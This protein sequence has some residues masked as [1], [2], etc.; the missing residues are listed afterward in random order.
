[1]RSR[2]S[3]GTCGSTLVSLSRNDGIVVGS[4]L[5]MALIGGGIGIDGVAIPGK[6]MIGTGGKTFGRPAISK[7]TSGVGS[8][9]FKSGRSLRT[10]RIL[11]ISNGSRL[12]RRN[13]HHHH[14]HQPQHQV[15]L[16]VKCPFASVT[17]VGPTCD[18]DNHHQKKS[19]SKAVTSA[20]GTGLP[21][22]Q[23]TRPWIV[24]TRHQPS[25]R[26]HHCGVTTKGGSLSV[27]CLFH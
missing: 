12:Q 14:G 17:T 5:L 2:S 19:T 16:M 9:N 10:G 26:I 25:Q 22:A 4:T 27:A 21:S 15:N 11:S 13:C 3:S 8:L 7:D 23:V 6:G 1:M 18:F 20:P 24:K